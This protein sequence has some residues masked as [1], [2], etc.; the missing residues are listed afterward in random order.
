MIG[1]GSR[2][3]A[4]ISTTVVSGKITRRRGSCKVGY[5]ILDQRAK[6]RVKVTTRVWRRR[7]REEVMRSK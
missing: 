1:T 6:S 2:D 4:I 3:D 5:E 7:E